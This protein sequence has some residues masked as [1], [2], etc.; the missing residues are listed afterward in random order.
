MTKSLLAS[1][2]LLVLLPAHAEISVTS[3]AFTYGES[4]DSLTTTTGT[5]VAWANDSTLAGWSLFTK[6]GNPITTYGA[7]NGGS[8][9]GSFRSY[10]STGSAERALGGAASGGAYFGSPA[11][12]AV[13]G[14]IAAAFTNNS[15]S[16]L[17]GFSVAYDG[18]QWRNGGNA[19]AQTMVMEYGFGTSFGSVALWT[20]PGGMA[21]FSSPVVGTTAGAVDGNALGLL[22]GLGTSVGSLDWAPGETLWV[23][24]TERNDA[25]AD[26]GL[27]VDNFA[28]SV[29]VVPEPQTWALMLAG[30]AA[31]GFMVRRRG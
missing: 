7:D 21:D 19:S 15:G 23:R 9:T 8:N 17:G 28:F 12:G 6:D 11:T 22:T 26:H 31:L 25:G 4:F 5:A 14:W 30:A 29:G 10:G 13:A 27:A 18:E 16:T 3:A 24:F 2:A 20:A 1:A